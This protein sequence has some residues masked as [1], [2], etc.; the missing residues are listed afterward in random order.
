MNLRSLVLA[1]LAGALLAVP[2]QADP[3][4]PSVTGEVA[5][6]STVPFVCDTPGPGEPPTG[7]VVGALTAPVPT[8][9]GITLEWAVQSGSDTN[10]NATAAVRYRVTGAADWTEGMPLR[11]I[12]ADSNEG[13]SWEDR[14]SG[15]L[16]DTRPGTSYDV[17]VQAEDPDGGCAV[18]SLTVQTPEI[19]TV[20]AD[21]VVRRTG[22]GR[23]DSVLASAAPGQVIELRAGTYA[24]FSVPVDGTASQPLVIRADGRVVVNGEIGLYDR[25]WVQV[26]GLVVHGRIRANGSANVAIVGNRVSGD[27][28]GGIQA[29]LDSRRAY[30]AKNVVTGPTVW[31]NRSV[32]ADGDNT[33]EG[34][35]VT[36]PGHVIERNTASGWRDCLSMMEDSEAIDQYSI[37]IRANRLVHCADDAIE[38][39]FCF[40]NCRVTDNLIMSSFVAMSSQPG[41]GGPT[42][43]IRNRAYGILYAPFKL[44]RGSIGDVILNNTMVKHGDAFNI[45]SGV[46]HRRQLVRNNIFLGGP[47]GTYGGYS[48][49]SGYTMSLAYDRGGSYDYDGYGTTRKVLKGVFRDVHWT[50]M[51]ELHATTTEQHAVHLSLG[52]FSTRMAYPARAF[53]HYA[54]PVFTLRPGSAAVDHGVYLPGLGLPTDTRPDLGA[55]QL[56]ERPTPVG[57]P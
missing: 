21:A 24:G 49:D 3:T 56:G 6:A 26:R 11:R 57:A 48:G 31:R 42:Y 32:G 46:V 53:G 1:P 5:R 34:I 22:P 37:D 43:F 45:Y 27:P 41:L 16:F 20:P 44:Y 4:A 30:I 52:V 55:I 50:G 25:R 36:G 19:P 40:H 10:D 23:L 18:E 29:V 35:V 17:E 2:V 33:G 7:L 9:R 54:V 47:G 39:D 51:D 28:E 12:P 38:A 13:F 8:Q 15:S 14:L